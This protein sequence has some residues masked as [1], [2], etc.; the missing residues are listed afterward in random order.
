MFI[1]G[2]F[3]SVTHKEIDAVAKKNK[4]VIDKESNRQ[5]KLQK[6]LTFIVGN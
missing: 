6:I 2:F 1:N 4:I 3:K 5:V